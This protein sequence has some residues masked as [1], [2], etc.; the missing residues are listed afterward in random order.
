M[1]KILDLFTLSKNER[2]MWLCSVLCL[3]LGFSP[4]LFNFVWGN[5]DWQPIVFGNSL[6]GGLVEGRFSQYAVQTFLLGGKV[7]PIINILLGFIIYTLSLVLLIHR[8]F[9]LKTSDTA[10]I[11]FVTATASVPFIIE[12]LYFHFIVFNMLIWPFV[13]VLSLLAA[14]K[15]GESSHYIGYTLFCLSLLFIVL[16]GYPAAGNLFAIATSCQLA[17]SYNKTPDIKKLF[18]KMLPYAISIIIAFIGLKYSF[19]WF[20]AAGYMKDMYN[21]EEATMWE[22][23]SKTPTIIRNSLISFI[24]P[25]PYFPVIFKVLTS[26]VFFTFFVKYLKKSKTIIDGVLRFIII[27]AILLSLKF[28]AWI[29][30]EDPENF[31]VQHDPAS[32][33]VRADFFSFPCFLLFCLFYL[34]QECNHLRKNILIAFSISLIWISTFQ[35]LSFAKTF[36]LGFRA[37]DKVINRVIDRIQQNP[38]FLLGVDYIIVQTGEIP[39]RS[40]YHTVNPWEKYGYY[41]TVIPYTRHWLAHEFYNFYP[42]EPFVKKGNNIDPSQMPPALITFISKKVQ[43]WPNENSIYVDNNYAII[44]LSPKGREMMIEQFNALPDKFK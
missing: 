34:S 4:L 8:F 17:L 43:S 16:G 40:K 44:A 9:E 27:A 28:A 13:L 42:P 41:T 5:H 20:K 33:M 3:V 31:F 25:Q 30:H 7:F 22:I 36:V 26:L 37:E 18:W 11:I 2:T 12:I 15:A 6:T 19:R 23:I 1:Q 38:N 24:Q 14:K 29:V 21:T 39:L 35:N 32:Y 10:G